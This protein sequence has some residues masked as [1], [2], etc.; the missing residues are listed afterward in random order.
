MLG[1]VESK[2]YSKCHQNCGK[3]LKPRLI[4][5]LDLI[6][7]SIDKIKFLGLGP[8]FMIVLHFLKQLI[9]LN[10][11]QFSRSQAGIKPIRVNIETELM[12]NRCYCSGV[13]ICAGEGCTYTVSTKQRVNR[14][15]EHKNAALLSTGLCSCYIAYVYPENPIEDG[16]R[17]FVIL[18]AE[19]TG[20]IHNHSSPPEWKIPPNVL[21]D[22]TNVAQK[23]MRITPKEVQNG[24]GMEYIKK[25]RRKWIMK[26]VDKSR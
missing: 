1:V 15:P 9:S 17:W 22:I 16:R 21:R 20:P 25:E 24:V 12:A 23:N 7:V 5:A 26:E 4:A 19:Q 14:C 6:E 8:I 10:V 18:N 3:Q 13:K 11:I 2:K